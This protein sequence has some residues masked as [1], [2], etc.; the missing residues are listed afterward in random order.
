VPKANPVAERFVRT[1]H[2]ECLDW[3]LILKRRH[4]ERALRVY[5]STTTPS[6][7]T[8]LALRPPDAP[9]AHTGTAVGEIRRRDIDLTHS[10][11]TGDCR[12][13]ECAE[14]SLEA[15][16]CPGLSGRHQLHSRPGRR[17]VDELGPTTRPQLALV[18]ELCHGR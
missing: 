1:V 7:R 16:G 14:I 17:Q 4:L 10:P 18:T 2:A 6:A 13:R 5:A 3:L 11:R 15:T 12:S 9:D 8:A